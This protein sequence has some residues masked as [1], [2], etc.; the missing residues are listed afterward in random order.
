MVPETKNGEFRR[1]PMEAELAAEIRC[2]VGRLVSFSTNSHGSFAKAV[3]LR[4]GISTFHPHRMRHTFACQWLEKGRNIAAL[5]QV[6]GHKTI[7]TT[8]RYAGLSDDAVMREITGTSQPSVTPMS[9]G[10][11][12]EEVTR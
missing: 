1:V 12:A 10:G 3:R 11:G 6:L 2:R 4:S 5:K 8:E 7:S 9:P